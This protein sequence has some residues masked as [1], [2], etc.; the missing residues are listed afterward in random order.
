MLFSLWLALHRQPHE[1]NKNKV[2]ALS[3]LGDVVIQL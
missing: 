1:V 3:F 2:I